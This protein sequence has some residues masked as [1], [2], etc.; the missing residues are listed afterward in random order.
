VFPINLLNYFILIIMFM[1]P[2]L[3]VTEFDAVQVV[4]EIV[5]IL[6]LIAGLFLVNVK[7]IDIFLLVVLFFFSTLSL[8]LNE[9]TVFLL[10]F[11]MF[12][13]TILV[14][15]YFSKIQFY[16]RKV[17][18]Y[19]LLLNVLY[20][21]Y[22]K[23]TGNYI[24][25]NLYFLKKEGFYAES[26][27]IGFLGSPHATSTFIAIYLLYLFNLGRYRLFQLLL[28]LTLLIYSSWTALAAFF[29][30]VIFII[31]DKIT[32]FKINQV[33]FFFLFLFSTLL[34][35]DLL[36]KFLVDVPGSR[37]YSVDA[38][39]P[40]FFDVR[41]YEPLLTMYPQSSESVIQLQEQEFAN[42]GNEFGLV[43]IFIEG[44]FVLSL[45]LIYRVVGCVKYMVVFLL[46]TT[47]HYS[48]FANI[49]LIM[50]LFI[51]LNKDIL[52]ARCADYIRRKAMVVDGCKIH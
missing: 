19:F 21:I 26:R 11:K 16:P 40:M 47:L 27:P 38:M 15:A 22:V 37:Y 28:F 52:Q 46:T 5:L 48:F 24:L 51:V 3:S 39:L 9:I 23:I 4:F 7:K 31:F 14:I 1:H 13:L 49:P 12:L 2:F 29:A 10:N 50:F 20:A 42:I 25:E 30:Q 43:K 18:L 41:F 8:L 32:P 6:L 35:G 17:I 34:I 36:L 44:G 33:I 45:L